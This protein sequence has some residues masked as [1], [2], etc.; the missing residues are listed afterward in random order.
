MNIEKKNFNKGNNKFKDKEKTKYAEFKNDKSINK[1]GDQL[2]LKIKYSFYNYFN[3]KNIIHKKLLD[4]KIIIYYLFIFFLPMISFSKKITSKLR[5][6]NFYQEITIKVREGEQKIINDNFS[7]FPDEIIL[8]RNRI[9]QDYISNG[10]ALVIQGNDNTVNLRWNNKLSTC[11][12][13]F[14]ALDHIISIDLSNFDF[15]SVTS[16]SSM[17]FRCYNL[18]YINFGN[19]D[20]SSLEEMNFMFSTCLSLKTLDLSNFNTKKVT[21]MGALFKDCTSLISL[22]LSSFDTS[23]VKDISYMFNN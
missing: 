14:E 6:L 9:T 3:Y 8:N 1:V 16:M 18:Q 13:M 22:D 21:N 12:Q 15:S 19:I 2:N 23:K 20:T 10:K 11:S 4:I 5:T 7:P 17:F